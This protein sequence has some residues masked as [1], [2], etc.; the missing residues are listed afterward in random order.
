[1]GRCALVGAGRAFTCDLGTIGAGASAA[2]L[3]TYT[4]PAATPAGPQTD[5][6]SVSSAVS[7]PDLTNNT[8]SDTNTVAT[9]ANLSVTKDDG[10]RSETRRVGKEC[11][12]QGTP[13]KPQ[14]KGGTRTQPTET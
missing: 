1:Q 2:V 11:R 6:V 4:V 8:A 12:S 3:V 10:V 7:D 13:S 9:S 14:K 5:T